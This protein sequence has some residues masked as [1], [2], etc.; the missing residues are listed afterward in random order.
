MQGDVVQDSSD[1]TLPLIKFKKERHV[2]AVARL[3]K[4]CEQER[5]K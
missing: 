3:E 5:E 2:C 4:Q 1:V